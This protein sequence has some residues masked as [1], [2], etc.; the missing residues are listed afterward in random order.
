MTACA[1]AEKSADGATACAARPTNY[2]PKSI[3]KKDMNWAICTDGQYYNTHPDV[4]CTACTAI[5]ECIAGAAPTACAQSEVYDST[6]NFAVTAFYT[7]SGDGT[8]RHVPYGKTIS[9]TTLADC[10]VGQAFN[11]KAATCVACTS[12]L[13]Y[14]V[15]DSTQKFSC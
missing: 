11:V 7:A 6:G 4:S 5:K 9:G 1:A 14:N 10:P 15:M 8:C 2:Y 12:G 13:C 3:S